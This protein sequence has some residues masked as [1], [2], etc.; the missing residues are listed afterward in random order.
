MKKI[1][2]FGIFF[3]LTAISCP[4]KELDITIENNTNNLYYFTC[5]NGIDDITYVLNR[6]KISEQ[7]VIIIN[8]GNNYPEFLEPSLYFYKKNEKYVFYF[9]KEKNYN[10]SKPIFDS[11]SISCDELDIDK[12]IIFTIDKDKIF[13]K[14]E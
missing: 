8:I 9:I 10:L 14:N 13:L 5:N 11:I 2:L 7:K 6:N 1:I 12:K 4:D 3:S